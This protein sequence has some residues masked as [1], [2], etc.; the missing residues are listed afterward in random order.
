MPHHRTRSQISTSSISRPISQPTDEHD[1]DL[2]PDNRLSAQPPSFSSNPSRYFDHPISIAEVSYHSHPLQSPAESAFALEYKEDLDSSPS[3]A[4]NE[5]PSSSLRVWQ[6]STPSFPPSSSSKGRLIHNKQLPLPLLNAPA[7][8]LPRSEWTPLKPSF[9]LL[10]KYCSSRELALAFPAIFVSLAAGGMAP[11]MS[12]VVGDSFNAFAFFPLDI[13]TATQDQKDDLR[14]KTKISALSLMAM[15]IGF[16][17]LHTL[18]C[19]LWVWIG[20]RNVRAIRREVYSKV[21]ARAIEWFDLGMGVDNGGEEVG[22][23]KEGGVGA[24]GLMS[25]FNR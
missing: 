16:I 10:Y 23:D 8:E 7:A 21:G 18:M 5:L 24:A 20:E 14:Q 25:K 22:E 19:G 13:R 11:Y 9:R 1:A 3:A 12:Q 17:I 15:G 2:L 4:Q 6:P